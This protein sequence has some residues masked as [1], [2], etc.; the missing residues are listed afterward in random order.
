MPRPVSVICFKYES[1]FRSYKRRLTVLGA[2]DVG[3]KFIIRVYDPSVYNAIRGIFRV[4]QISSSFQDD[5][6][7]ENSTYLSTPLYEYS[8]RLS[9]DFLGCSPLLP[10]DRNGE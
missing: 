7:V 2:I 5:G 10:G 8:F 3:K 4:R 1:R 9:R 6:S